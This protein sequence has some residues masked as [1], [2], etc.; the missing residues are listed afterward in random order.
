MPT[1]NNL[2]QR[3]YISIVKR[4]EYAFSMVCSW[5][6]ALIMMEFE[7]KVVKGLIQGSKSSCSWLCRAT[8]ESWP[9]ND[10]I[11]WYMASVGTSTSVF[12][13]FLR[14]GLTHSLIHSHVF[15]RLCDRGHAQGQVP[16]PTAQ[17]N[18]IHRG[19]RPQNGNGLR[20]SLVLGNKQVCS[21]L[22]FV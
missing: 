19:I 16:K 1:D 2:V 7:Y 9:G 21:L 10:W 22:N 6:S 3:T 14:N 17:S 15:P 4:T 20:F 5:L 18:S 8:R 11:V 13:S 12:I